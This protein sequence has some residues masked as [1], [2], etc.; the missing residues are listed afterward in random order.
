[1]QFVII[2]P[3]H[4]LLNSFTWD[5]VPWA[6]QGK[7][8]NGGLYNLS[9]EYI[10]VFI[11]ADTEV[12]WEQRYKIGRDKRKGQK[13][14]PRASGMVENVKV[15]SAKENAGRVSVFNVLQQHICLWIP[16]NGGVFSWQ[17]HSYL[18]NRL[19]GLFL[20]FRGHLALVHKWDPAFPNFYIPI[21]FFNRWI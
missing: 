19:I 14:H 18:F 1:M 13:Q 6:E 10:F 5:T 8:P 12:Y 9:V 3:L 16:N 7:Q 20:L 4:S 15:F 17:K 21:M 2:L 11:A